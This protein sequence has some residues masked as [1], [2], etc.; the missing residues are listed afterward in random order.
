MSWYKCKVTFT[1]SL[2]ELEKR[3]STGANKSKKSTHQKTTTNYSS[4]DGHFG[5]PLQGETL[6]LMYFAAPAA[7]DAMAAF[8][9]KPIPAAPAL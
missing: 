7:V 5:P 8:P 3:K 4:S 6:S 9:A 1:L 2:L